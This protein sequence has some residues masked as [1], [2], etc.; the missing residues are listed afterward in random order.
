M[1][2]LNDVYVMAASSGVQLSKDDALRIMNDINSGIRTTEKVQSDLQ[3]V[4]NQ[5]SS[6]NDA[7]NDHTLASSTVSGGKYTAQDIINLADSLNVDLSSGSPER[8][9]NELNSGSRTISSVT[10]D[11]RWVADQLM[12]GNPT[13]GHSLQIDPNNMEEIDPSDLTG[14]M[15]AETADAI[16]S[17]MLRNYGLDYNASTIAEWVGLMTDNSGNISIIEEQIRQSE[18]FKQRFPGLDQRVANGYNQITVEE[19]LALEDQYKTI[20][21]N[22]DMPQSFYDQPE[23]FASFIAGDVSAAEF[24]SRVVDGLLAA[25]NAPDEVKQMLSEYYNVPPNALAAYYLDPERGLEAIQRQYE[26]AVIGSRAVTTGF[27]SINESQ[28]GNLRGMGV[29]AEEAEAGFSRLAGA[30]E[31]LSQNL[32]RGDYFSKED[33]LAMQFSKDADVTERFRRQQES[34]LSR[35]ANFSGGASLTRRGSGAGSADDQ[36]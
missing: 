34:R 30:G 11:I 24:E 28:A 26:T 35:F 29:T 6:G 18:T 14:G 22:A 4:S 31:L 10:S 5:L 33:Q 20:M 17:Q 21:R 27:G 19:Y 2:T 3:W 32:G 16:I 25:E 23:D 12:Q 9:A 1:A 13:G 8:I 15:N 7:G 36:G